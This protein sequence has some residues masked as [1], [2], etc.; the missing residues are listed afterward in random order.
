MQGIHATI[1]HTFHQGDAVVDDYVPVQSP[2]P[3]RARVSLWEIAKAFL[4]IGST[5]FGGGMA[6]IALMQDYAVLRK[7]WLG[8]DEFSHGIALGQIMGPFAVNASIFVGYRLRGWI[9]G[10]VAV[11]AFLTPSIILVMVLT[12]L[13]L[14]YQ[15]VPALQSALVGIGPVVVALI[16]TAAYDM[17]HSRVNSAEGVLLLVASIVMSAVFNL[18]IIAVL[19]AAAVYGLLKLRFGKGAGADEAS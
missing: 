14:R 2:Q 18:P 6:I 9:G 15:R 19:G 13:Y 5:G 11:T 17:I 10:V 12:H 3:V 4:I 16:V 8:L 7:R 1:G